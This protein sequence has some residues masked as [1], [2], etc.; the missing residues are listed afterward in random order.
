MDTKLKSKAKPLIA[1]ALLLA[2]TSAAFL[3]G[4]DVVTHRAFF[5]TSYYFK[6]NAFYNQIEA[7]WKLIKYIHLDNKNY[8]Q[9]PREDK[10]NDDW[11]LYLKKSYDEQKQMNMNTGSRIDAMLESDINKYLAYKELEYNLVTN[12]LDSRSGIFK[13]YIKDV[14]SGEVYTNIPNSSEQGVKLYPALYRIELPTNQLT[15][16]ALQP[17]NRYFQQNRL[18]G[19]LF[20]PETVNEH[21]QIHS[22]YAY[23]LAI[24]ERIIK[25]SVLF[26]V[27]FLLT[28]ILIAVIRKSGW[29]LS[30]ASSV[31]NGF[32]Q[33]PLDARFAVLLII[34][35]VS[36]SY[37]HPSE[38]FR[39]PV[40]PVRVLPVVFLA[41]VAALLIL[42]W[43]EV[44]L[45]YRNKPVLKRQWQETYIFRLRQFIGG[46]VAN[47]NLFV[48][49]ALIFGASILL[50]IF[51]VVGIIGLDDGAGGAI[52]V[53]ALYILLYLVV[54]LPYILK[55]ISMLSS[56]LSGAE[57]IAAGDFNQP[58]EPKGRGNL[59]ALANH[60][61][62]MKAGFKSSLEQQMKSERL[63]SELITN[64]S[65]DLKT[66]LTSIINY[67][68]LLK[69]ENLT[70]DQRDNYIEVLDRKA[71]RLKALI[72]DLF[73]ASK[74]A[75]GATELTLE[76]VNVT[77][78]L[79][80]TLAE[81]SEQIE[82]SGLRFKITVPDK[83]VEAVLDGKKI[84][85]VFENLIGNALKYSTPNTRVHITLT[86]S[87]DK[88]TFSINNV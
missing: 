41:V 51:S 38:L 19:T 7:H 44:L 17:I 47:R 49:A 8:P 11:I 28:L 46:S 84:W 40:D 80:Q 5:D 32:R 59:A 86:E 20:I 15:N 61:N 4:W 73:E 63:K 6:S 23:Y 27:S 77:S 26:G 76:N 43:Q 14:G 71:Q 56:I 10:L 79:R 75:S 18:T 65:H 35:L 87:T 36:F 45:L 34:C 16:Q 74:M 55:R 68:D 53:S 48:K 31:Q 82:A 37:V 42:Q 24:R 58:I 85:R 69:Q 67:V 29:A 30:F 60:L 22:D 83:K 62:N 70:Q 2:F 72:D 13:Y 21:S 12:S 81:L 52:V 25:E 33:V 88:I 57:A 54:I 3:S 64:V 39:I 78:L 50:V 1:W 66:P 9:L